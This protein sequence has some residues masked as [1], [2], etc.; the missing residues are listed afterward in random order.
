MA[1]TKQAPKGMATDRLLR[2]YVIFIFGL[3]FVAL[4]CSIIT[5][6]SL[7]ST[8]LSA[9][10]YSLS[11]IFTQLTFG[12][13]TI[14]FSVI[15]VTVYV[16]C[17]WKD[18]NKVDKINVIPA[19]ALCVV[20]G[21]ML[22]F[23]MAILGNLDFEYWLKIVAI[24][25]GIGI[26]AFGT[27]MCVVSHSILGPGD[28]F[29]YGLAYRSGIAYGHVRV[30][31]DCSLIIIAAIISFAALGTLGGVREGTIIAA[32]FTGFVMKFYMKNFKA[33]TNL[34]IP[35]EDITRMAE[36]KAAAD[37]KAAA[38]GSEAKERE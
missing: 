36:G 19:Y 7:G 8:P 31:T 25:V 13:W 4:G 26:E 37:A 14:L 3:F 32:I 30:T 24:F 23:W 22:D 18:W 38:E 20:Y 28:A 34:L 15:I 21:Y 11:M 33:I 16:L 9:V 35:G 27:Y 29:N 5:K 2:R 17:M 6:M 12:N 10:P 1:E